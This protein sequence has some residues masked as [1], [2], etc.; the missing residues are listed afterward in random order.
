MK[1]TS[2]NSNNWWLIVQGFSDHQMAKLKKSE[3]L[4]EEREKEIE[5]AI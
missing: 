5:Q 3:Q 1:K 4:S 2:N